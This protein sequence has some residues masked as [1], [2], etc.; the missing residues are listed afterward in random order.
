MRI[1]RLALIGDTGG[2][3][4]DVRALTPAPEEV[5]AAVIETIEAVRSRG[6]S[7]LL[8]LSERFDGVRPTALRVGRDRIDSAAQLADPAVVEAL[9]IAAENIRAVAEAQ[10]VGDVGPVELREGHRVTVRNL[11]VAAAA[12]YV[13]GGTASYPSSVLMGALP[14]RAA[15]VER[16][17]VATPPDANGG[18]DPNVL[19]ACA[20]ADVD[21]VYPV[22]GAQAIAGLAFG[23]ETVEAVD[24]IA[25]P[26]SIRVQEAKLQVARTVGID[27]YA[28]PSELAVVFDAT[29]PI[30]WLA[31]DLCAQAEHGGAGLLVAIASE[32]GLLDRLEEAVTRGTAEWPS[33]AD[34]PLALIEAEDIES[35]LGLAD[36]IAPEHL[37]LAC[38]AAAELADAGRVAGCVLVGASAAT[39][40][41][42]Y[43][44]GSNHILPT[45]GAGRFVGPVGPGTF[46]RSMS[47]VE[48]PPAAA[49]EL[50]TPAQTLA[51]AEGFPVHG[52]SLRARAGSR[53]PT[54][55][56]GKMGER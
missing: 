6:D 21:E 41:S 24:V 1:S 3:A 36:A 29:A 53:R 39:A 8:E 4:A 52:E 15:G 14:A 25:G 37:Q 31:L 26:G 44:A 22:G 45:G 17:A 42:D 13:P 11:P 7:A 34:V 56:V 55:A 40:F 12:I 30:D 2:L 43:V 32:P 35:A 48:I 23:T 9:Q 51:D 19:A 38:D 27:F 46:R 47:I 50:A 54:G 18:I 16:V 33:V 49:M 5:S 28:G 10:L 20:I